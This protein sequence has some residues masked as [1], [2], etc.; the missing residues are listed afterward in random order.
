MNHRKLI[1]E[2]Q[3]VSVTRRKLLQALSASGTAVVASGALFR[4]ATTIA[5][6]TGQSTGTNRAFTVTTV[7][8][9]S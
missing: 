9:L 1:T 3:P 4:A 2:L 7:N 5:A 6:G 8:H